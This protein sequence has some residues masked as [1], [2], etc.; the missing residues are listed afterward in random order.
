MNIGVNN[1]TDCPLLVTIEG[2]DNSETVRIANK[3]G[4]CKVKMAKTMLESLELYDAFIDD[5][6]VKIRTIAVKAS[7]LQK[8]IDFLGRR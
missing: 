6:G 5:H 7:E 2:A 1:E 8:I 3:K 4:R